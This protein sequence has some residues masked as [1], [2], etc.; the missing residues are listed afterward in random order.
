MNWLNVLKSYDE[1]FKKVSSQ[2]IVKFCKNHYVDYHEK[3]IAYG[4]FIN[5]L[6]NL[7]INK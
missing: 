2:N 4:E 3:S 1:V 6:I 7:F 5:S